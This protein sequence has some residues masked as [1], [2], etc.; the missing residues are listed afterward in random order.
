VC[1][2]QL[3]YASA[4]LADMSKDFSTGASSVS[5]LR[6]KFK[7]PD[8]WS[9]EKVPFRSESLR[10]DEEARGRSGPERNGE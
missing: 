7:L 4:E 5:G 6:V 10:F 3:E 1:I 9:V 8:R 2:T